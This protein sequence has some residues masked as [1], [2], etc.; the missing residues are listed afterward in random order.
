MIRVAYCRG[1]CRVVIQGHAHS[2]EVGHDL[3]CAAVSALAYTLAGNVR[4]LESRGKV[5]RAFIRLESGEAQIRCVPAAQQKEQVR[6][7]FDGICLGFRLLAQRYPEYVVW[8]VYGG[9]KNS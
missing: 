7:V 2:A 1:L 9:R 6:Q 5:R 3:V 4:E 8:E